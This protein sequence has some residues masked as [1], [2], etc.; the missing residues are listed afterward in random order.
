MTRPAFLALPLLCLVSGCLDSLKERDQ[1]LVTPPGTR[2]P[3]I[4]GWLDP[5]AT[6]QVLWIEWSIPADSVGG[7]DPRPVDPDLVTLS[8]VGPDGTPVP[9]M[10]GEPGRFTAQIRVM[11]DSLYRLEGSIADTPVT[12]TVRI[13]DS[14]HFTTPA[15]DTVRIARDPG[16]FTVRFPYAFTSRGASVFILNTVDKHNDVTY[17]NRY[18]LRD[19]KGSEKL[20]ATGDTLS[21]LLDAYEP[22]GGEWVDL[23]EHPSASNITG[24]YGFLGAFA[25]GK[26]IIVIAQ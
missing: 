3:V 15:A 2:S 25:R 14:V 19:S 26:L 24:A 5:Q 9:L 4:Q 20:F 18:L 7:L 16:G 10:P 17:N 1:D 12:A 23:S 22:Y 21:V 13:P 8:L 11:P 6:V